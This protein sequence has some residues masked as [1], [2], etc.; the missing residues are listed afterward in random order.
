MRK[1]RITM[2]RRRESTNGHN[3][4]ETLATLIQNQASFLA[5]VS[6]M[7]Q[8]FGRIETI[9]AEHGRV[10]TDLTRLVN[11][12]AAELTAADSNRY[13]PREDRLQTRADSAI[14]NIPGGSHAGCFRA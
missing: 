5:R 4:E 13:D 7:D 1:G 9:L 14:L 2:P 11:T 6:E 8:R 12:H 10:L 3:L